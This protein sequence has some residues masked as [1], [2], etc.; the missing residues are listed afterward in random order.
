MEKLVWCKVKQFLEEL[1]C[2]DIDRESK[3]ITYEFEAAKQKVSDLT[4]SYNRCLAGL[5]KE[6]QETIQYYAA[7]WKE[8]SFEECQQAYLQ[9]FIDCVLVLC[10]SGV[11]RPQKDLETMLQS[12][13]QP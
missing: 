11:L 8:S 4:T 12:F 6:E 2:E 3:V 9:G 1:R 7:A 13:R 5:Q 10:G